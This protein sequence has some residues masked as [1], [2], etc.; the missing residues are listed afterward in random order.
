MAVREILKM[1]T[2]FVRSPTLRSSTRMP[3]IS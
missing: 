2:P 1:G 3:C